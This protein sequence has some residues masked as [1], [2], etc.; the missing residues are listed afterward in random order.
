VRDF[1]RRDLDP[2]PDKA[3][4]IW[5]ASLRSFKVLRERD[6][7]RLIELVEEDTRY[8]LAAS[9]VRLIHL[10]GR[11]ADRLSCSPTDADA[12][13]LA[14]EMEQ[15]LLARAL[16][17]EKSLI[18]THPDLDPLLAPL[19]AR[20]RKK[21]IITHVLLARAYRE[22][23]G[24]FAV[25]WVGRARPPFEQRAG[26]YYYWDNAG[27]A[28]AGVNEREAV[29]REL[30][31][32]PLTGLANERAF[33]EE[34]ARHGATVTLSLLFIDFDGLKEA[35]EHFGNYE[36]GGDVLIRAVGQALANLV[37]G[38]E[39]PARLHTA[40]DEFMVLLPGANEEA[41]SRR[42]EEL[43]S[44]L[45]RV[46]LPSSHR[47]V[48]RGASVGSATRKPGETPAQTR[49]RAIAAMRARKRQ[50]RNER[51]Q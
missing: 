37:R 39:F 41:A 12:P 38:G 28:L 14:T 35:N 40:G 26:F 6:R 20:C 31:A 48:Y 5:R 2:H 42:A 34:L 51:D 8:L 27:L 9:T 29:R 47:S 44:E 3:A 19:A 17:E 15:A 18:S 30:H 46:D 45:E 50:R 43:E 7:A 13:E 25:H 11:T 24:A 21:R 23:H 36:E 49:G 32:D 10:D 33:D 16:A 22:T 4:W 1:L